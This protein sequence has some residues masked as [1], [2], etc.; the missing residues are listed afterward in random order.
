MPGKLEDPLG[1]A[2]RARREAIG[3]LLATQ[4]YAAALRLAAVVRHPELVAGTLAEVWGEAADYETLISE[5]LGKSKNLDT[6][7]AAISGSAI[8][9]L[10]GTWIERLGRLVAERNYSPDAVVTLALPWPD[11]RK[12]LGCCNRTWAG[13]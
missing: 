2:E 10:G 3:E 8:N 11:V 6:F 7:A 4:G 12:K 5:T 9:K 13:G 1:A